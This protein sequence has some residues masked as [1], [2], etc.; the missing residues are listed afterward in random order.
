MNKHRFHYLVRRSHRF[1]GLFLGIQFL[2][3]TIGGLYFSWSDMDEIHGDYQKKAPKMLEV[4]TSLAAPNIVLDSV[5]KTHHG[6]QITHIQLF[7][8]LNKPTYRVEM[9]HEGHHKMHVLADAVSG[10]IRPALSEKEAVELAKI[11]FNGEPNVENVTYLT[12]TNG[13]HEYRESPLPAYA[14]RFS[15]PS[16]TTVYVSTN[17][18]IVTKFR[19]DKWRIFDFLWMLHTMDYNGRDNI[20]NVLLRIFSVI[21]LITICSGFL[22]FFVSR[23][24]K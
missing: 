23:K 19:N 21:G 20:G 22:L 15:H 17:M 2:F 11:Q 12:D 3:W 9:M 18:G 16:K 1:L 6:A 7:D 13:H 5:L 10:A 8:I 14:I 4:T 24:V